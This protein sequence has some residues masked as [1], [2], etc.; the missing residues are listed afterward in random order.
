[1]LLKIVYLSIDNVDPNKHLRIFVDWIEIS[2][3]K[4]YV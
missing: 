4:K 2:E 1:M 3:L